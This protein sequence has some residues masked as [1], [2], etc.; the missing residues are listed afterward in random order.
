[1]VVSLMG[2]LDG[3]ARERDCHV[4]HQ[5]QSANGRCQGERREHVVWAFEGEDP[6]RTRLAQ[7][8]GTVDRIGGPEQGGQD[9]HG[10]VT[11]DPLGQRAIEVRPG[12]SVGQ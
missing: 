10:T 2:Q 8:T 11:L 7:G 5:V 9:F 1:M 6:G 3:I 12:A 4:R